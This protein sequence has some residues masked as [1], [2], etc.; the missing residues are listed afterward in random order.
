MLCATTTLLGGC[1]PAHLTSPSDPNLSPIQIS[2]SNAPDL[3]RAVHAPT[4]FAQLIGDLTALTHNPN[5][6][7]QNV[8]GDANGALTLDQ[9]LDQLLAQQRPQPSTTTPRALTLMSGPG[10]FSNCTLRGI[11]RIQPA[12]DENGE[13]SLLFSAYTYLY[14]NDPSKPCP[15]GGGTAGPQFGADVTFVIKDHDTGSV[16]ISSMRSFYSGTILT[17]YVPLPAPYYPRHVGASLTTR[18]WVQD[19]AYM[20]DYTSSASGDFI[21]N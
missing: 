2:P 1:E 8:F 9:V 10:P 14:A 18:H 5:L 7:Q 19:N 12:I 17:F 6:Q 3:S 4:S 15:D 16:L 20:M 13:S 21:L 11:S